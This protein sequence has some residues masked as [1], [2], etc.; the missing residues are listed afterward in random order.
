M[1]IDL[2]REE[3]ASMP[4][5]QKDLVIFDNLQQIK[6]SVH[7]PKTCQVRNEVDNLRVYGALWLTILTIAIG[8]KKYLPF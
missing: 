8:L 2:S 7:S 5:K 6:E 4:R 1:P 3:F